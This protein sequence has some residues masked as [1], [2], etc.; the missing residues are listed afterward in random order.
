MGALLL[1]SEGDFGGEGRLGGQQ[2]PRTGLLTNGRMSWD[3]VCVC[4][5]N[6][7]AWGLSLISKSM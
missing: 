4:V 2:A 5:R 6:E 3:G 1:C 7:A